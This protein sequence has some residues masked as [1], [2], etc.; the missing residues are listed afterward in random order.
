MYFESRKNKEFSSQGHLILGQLNAG[1]FF[2][3][4]NQRSL[5]QR[6]LNELIKVDGFTME[7]QTE[8]SQVIYLSKEK[9]SAPSTV[10]ESV[11][12]HISDPNT[13]FVIIAAIETLTGHALYSSPQTNP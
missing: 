3:R 5:Y 11:F 12:E 8:N 7:K 10:K 6:T 1:C 4:R 13:T 2:T 9:L